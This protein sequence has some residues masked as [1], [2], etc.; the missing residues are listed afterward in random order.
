MKKGKKKST[1]EEG[2]LENSEESERDRASPEVV[3]G[4]GCFKGFPLDSHGTRSMYGKG[5]WERLE[6]V[7]RLEKMELLGEMNLW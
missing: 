7:K 3:G 1:R 6:V 4:A 5:W 2:V